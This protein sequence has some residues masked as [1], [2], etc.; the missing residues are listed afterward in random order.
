M[1]LGQTK[2]FTFYVKNEG[3]TTIFLSALDINWNPS[4]AQNYI[5]F[6]FDSDDQK[7]EPNEVRNVA[8]SLTVSLQIT[9]VTNYSFDVLLQG[10]DYLL[11]D[12][13]QDGRVDMKD[14]AIVGMAFDATPTSIHWNPK[15]DLNRDLIVNMCDVAIVSH[16]RA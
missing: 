11:A 2:E 16:A 13:N 7:V 3:L 9:D 14:V 6:T 8:C 15:A 5:H 1:T 10:T 12:V 4:A